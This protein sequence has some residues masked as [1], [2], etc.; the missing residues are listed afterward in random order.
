MF[1]RRT[2]KA[3]A[4]SRVALIVVFILALWVTP[5][6]GPSNLGPIY[7]FL[8]IYL[9]GAV[10]MAGVAWTSWWYEYRLAR[11]VHSIDIVAFVTAVYLSE[12]DS[13]DFN[14][15]YPTVTAFLLASATLRWGWS[16]VAR[17]SLALIVL[18]AVVG[19]GLYADGFDLDV[20]LYARRLMY[21]GVFAMA[22]VWLNAE[23]R[24]ARVIS[25]PR[26]PG[27]PGE[28]RTAML[29]D[30][31]AF[32]RTALQGTGAAIA[33][34]RGEEPWT[35]VLRATGD[36]MVHDRLGPE[37]LDAGFGEP[38]CA[39][40]IDIPRARRIMSRTSTFPVALPGPF[41]APLAAYCQVN[42]GILVTFETVSGPGQ[43]LVWGIS[44]MCV[45]DLPLIEAMGRHLGAELD[46]EEMAELARSASAAALRD[47]LARDLH[48][49]VAQFLAG[50]LFRLEALTRWIKAGREPIGEINEIKAALRREQGELRETIQR[51][52]RGEDGDRR[53]DLVGELEALLGE[54]GRHWHIDVRLETA[55]PT[56]PVPI[57]LAYEV[58]QV[59]REAVA[60]AVRHG[61]CRAVVVTLADTGPHLQLTFT[62]DGVGFPQN[63]PANRPRS[64]AERVESLGGTFAIRNNVPGVLLE[65]VLPTR[66][67]G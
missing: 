52:R 59:L 61:Q 5:V 13:T 57:G 6:K 67:A 63:V 39:T 54:L 66:E 14:S 40:L 50:T 51:L 3:L 58:R 17:T 36:A 10:A 20:Y 35:E 64:I 29:I 65:I 19:V 8:A 30:M 62:D 28:R 1:A 7:L 23:H 27:N 26:T 56:L 48:D 31:L 16:G 32:S 34:G 11:L 33:I 25:M 41:P 4:T 12:I 15:P 9:A 38:G 45:D 46:R 47:A 44:D 22:M 60:N 49:S 37:V 2:G 18:S 43:L 55:A 21:F 24:T 42:E 53:T